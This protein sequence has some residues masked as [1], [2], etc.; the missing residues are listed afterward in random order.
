MKLPSL[1]RPRLRKRKRDDIA[2]LLEKIRQL[3][4]DTKAERLRDELENPGPHR[5]VSVL[6]G[7]T[8]IAAA[9]TDVARI[10]FYIFLEPICMDR[11]CVASPM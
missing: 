3:P 4:P 11:P 7:F 6:F 9:I 10:L 2:R 5:L 1:N 8:D